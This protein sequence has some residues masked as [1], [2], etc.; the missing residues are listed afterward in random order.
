MRGENE[1]MEL[2]LGIAEN[3]ERVRAV[4]MN[5]SRANPAVPRDIYQDY[6]IVFAVT[7][8]QSFLED[9]GWISQFGTPLIVQEPDKNDTYF[10]YGQEPE[11]FDFSRRYTWLMLFNDGTRIDLRIE[12]L[13]ESEKNFLSESLTVLLLDKDN[14]MPQLP[15]PSDKDYHIQKPD[16]P[17]FHACCNNFWWCLNNAAKGIARD[18][19]PYAMIMFH[20]TVRTDLHTMMDWY[21]GTLRGFSVST[22]KDGKFYKKLLP[23]ELYLMYTQTFSGSGYEQF[24][25]ALD[26]MCGLFH[27]LAEGVSRYFGFSYHQDEEDGMREYIRMVKD[28]SRG[29]PE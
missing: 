1:M 10:N 9:P 7:G 17:R 20:G 11:P 27:I 18:E 21:T 16:E 8:T 4:Y 2:I 13:E 26:T 23:P 3:D 24:W 6:D 19:L 29:E 15:P 12:T 5:G 28:L 25:D 22:G 14:R